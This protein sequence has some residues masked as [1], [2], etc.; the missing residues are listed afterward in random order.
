M[1]EKLNELTAGLCDQLKDHMLP[2]WEEIPDLDLYMDQVLNL[3]RRHLGSYPGFEETGLTSS[4]VNN[5]V[6]A[7][8]LPPP[9]RK[10]YATEH[11]ARLFMI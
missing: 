2:R 8:L 4:M 7:G 11:V 6:K 10:R 1:D 3:V 9:V 5:Y